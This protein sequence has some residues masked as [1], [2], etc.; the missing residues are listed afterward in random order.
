MG[1][2]PDQCVRVKN[3]VLFEDNLCQVLKIHLVDD[4]DGRRDN[5]KSLKGLLAPFKELV[6]FPVALKFN[7][8]IVREGRSRS[9][10]IHLDGVVNHQVDGNQGLDNRG[11]AGDRL[12]GIPH[13]SQVHQKWN[14]CKVLQDNTADN[15][16]NLL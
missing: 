11:I 9:G 15:E 13:R 1:V 5:R 14:P 10:A 12:D 6:A 4:T 3:P 8:Q 7:P 2:G 16:G